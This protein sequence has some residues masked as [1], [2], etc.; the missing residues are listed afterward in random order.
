EI[1]IKAT[2]YG[3]LGAALSGAGPTL[4]TLVDTNSLRKA[5][6]EQFLIQTLGR[7]GIKAETMWLK[8]CATGPEITILQGEES[9]GSLLER[10]KGEVRA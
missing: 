4:L 2:E 8:P 1:L 9:G 10:I 5:E 3:A 6:L 7:A